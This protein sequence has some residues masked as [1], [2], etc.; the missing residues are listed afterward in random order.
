MLMKRSMSKMLAVICLVILSAQALIASDEVLTQIS[1]IDALMTGIYD[2]TTSLGELR[3]NGDLGIGTM[4]TLDGELVLLDGIFYQVTSDGKVIRPDLT[5]KTPFAVVTFFTA[6]RN[7]TLK[8][9]SNFQEFT[10]N[11]EKWFPSRNI[12]YAVKL[13]GTFKAVKTRSVPAQK[14]PYSPLAEIVKTQ[15]VFEIKNVTGTVVGFW[16][17]S[18]VKGMNVP[19]YHLH[20]ISSDGKAGGHVLDFVTDNV[21]AEFDDTREFS[22]ILPDDNDFDKANLEKDRA[23]EVKAVEK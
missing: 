3:K 1:T 14:K 8:Q 17:P 18:Y 7:I 21:I 9:G 20:F 22:L 10:G 15:P 16:S 11:T 4:N 6:N 13:K 19:G 5:A 23:A 12:F 2:G